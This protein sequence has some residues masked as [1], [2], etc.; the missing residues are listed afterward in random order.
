M[1]SSNCLARYQQVIDC[2]CESLSADFQTA[3]LIMKSRIN[4]NRHLSHINAVVHI[5]T[6]H[7]RNSLLDGSFASQNLNHRSVQPYSLFSAR[8]FYAAA[9]LTFTDNAGRIDVT[10]FKR[11]DI[12][13]ALC[14]D[15][16]RSYGTNLLCNKRPQNLGR[17]N[18]ACRMILDRILIQKLCSCTVAQNQSVCSCAIVVGC[19]KSLIM[20]TSRTA[21][22]DDNS[23][24]L[25]HKIVSGFHI[26]KNG[27]R[28]LA[29]VILISSTAEVNSTTGI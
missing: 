29:L 10:G 25:C 11:M 28:C 27:S 21:C 24:C 1:D 9:F 15:K 26:Q 23:L 14:I 6:E 2:L 19:R 17:I 4:Q 8:N 20:H 3:V 13:L 18:S 5:H 22:C 7:C 12:R 16:L